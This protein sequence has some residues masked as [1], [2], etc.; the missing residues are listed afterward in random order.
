MIDTIMGPFY[1]EWAE[2]GASSYSMEVIAVHKI[3]P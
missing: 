1:V 2:H 3:V